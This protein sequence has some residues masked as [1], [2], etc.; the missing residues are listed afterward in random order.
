[1]PVGFKL[2][3]LFII[4]N[5]HRFFEYNLGKWCYPDRKIESK[6]LCHS[7]MF[8]RL[9]DNPLL[10]NLKHL[11]LTVCS[12]PFKLEESNR[13]TNLMHLKINHPYGLGTELN[14]NLPKLKVL[15]IYHRSFRSRLSIDCPSLSV[16][17]YNE[18]EELNLLDVKHPETIRK[19]ETNM[20]G[21]KLL[22]FKRVEFW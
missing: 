6:E 16:L 20:V 13:F 14:L 1:M 9:I 10:S 11:A 12:F 5:F 7:A 18:R 3:R 8:S 19:L 4:Q 21:S 2:D 22:R 17:V 15:V